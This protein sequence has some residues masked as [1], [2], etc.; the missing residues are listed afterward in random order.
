[1]KAPLVVWSHDVDDPRSAPKSAFDGSDHSGAGPAALEGDLRLRR[2]SA[3]S[4]TCLIRQSGR[5]RPDGTRRRRLLTG[6][7]L[8]LHTPAEAQESSLVSAAP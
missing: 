8:R 1:M 5:V 7:E 3:H 2:A 6:G 4:P